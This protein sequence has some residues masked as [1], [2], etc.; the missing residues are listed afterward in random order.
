MKYDFPHITNI[1]QVLPHVAKRPEFIVAEKDGG[2]TVINYLVQ[3]ADTFPPVQYEA[4]AILRECRGMIF[5]TA[6]GEVIARRY[7]KFF[8]VGEKDETQ[9]NKID[10]NEP[11]V[12][13]EKLDGSMITPVWTDAGL[14]WGTKMGVTDVA[15]P[16]EEFV[17]R[18]PHYTHYANICRA[19][20]FTPIFEWCSRKQAIVIDH[21]VD[22]LVLTALRNTITGEYEPYDRMKQSLN[23]LAI[24]IVEAYT[25]TVENM[26]A[27]LDYTRDLVGM[28]GFVVRFDSGHMLKVKAADYVC[29]HKAKDMIG[30]EKNVIEIIV[31]EK[32]DDVKGFLDANDLARFEEFERKFWDGVQ[33]TVGMLQALRNQC[34]AVDRKTYAVEFVQ[35]R[36]PKFSRFLYKMINPMSNTE[37]L[38][39]VKDSIAVSCGTGTKVE[40]ARWLFNCHWNEQGEE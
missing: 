36:D 23:E 29:K 11:H 13:L 16:V 14:R 1:S 32:A 35:K 22:R 3:M 31:T 37:V 8:N 6:T 7:H 33:V 15:L 25:G 40:E 21:P 18:N 27:L 17:S 26:Q 19:A 30:R 20:G 9:I 34:R 39:L 12:I 28:E 24:P 5:N 10:F 2:Y 4:D 38:E